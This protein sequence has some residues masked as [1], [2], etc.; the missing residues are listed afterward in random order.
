MKED[1]SVVREQIRTFRSLFTQDEKNNVL[2]K[3][4]K[5]EL[6]RAIL[7]IE[8]YTNDQIESIMSL[9]YETKF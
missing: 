9:I 8:S 6:K 2:Q 1:H 7:Q 4:V 5:E 3:E